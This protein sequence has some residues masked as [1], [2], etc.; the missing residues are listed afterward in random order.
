MFKEQ[1]TWNITLCLALSTE[2]L[3][4]QVFVRGLFL[5]LVNRDEQRPKPRRSHRQ[6]S[7]IHRYEARGLVQDQSACANGSLGDESSDFLRVLDELNTDTFSDSGVRLL[8]FD[9]NF[10]EH[11]ALAVGGTTGW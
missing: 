7:S 5:R 10:F 3:R 2:T 4:N 6:S 9:A 8:G 1:L 11:N